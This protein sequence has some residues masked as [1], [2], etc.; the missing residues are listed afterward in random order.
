MGDDPRERE[1]N[2]R[3]SIERW[4]EARRRSSGV[5]RWFGWIAAVISFFLFR[6]RR[7]LLV[8]LVLFFGFLVLLFGVGIKWTRVYDC[9]VAE[10]SHS[11]AVLEHL[12]HPVE[13][14]FFAWCPRY[15]QG[16]S[17]T[18]T[19]FRTTLKGPKGEGILQVWW[20][21]SPLG[22]SLR[23][24]LDKNGQTHQVYSGAIPCH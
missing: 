15:S 8:V 2:F 6:P 22:S 20:Y 16:G 24:E 10:A 1:Q 18:D 14:G 7:A 12:G 11:S 21:S 3:R 19:S 13:A 23:M 9:S 17:I 5:R 4:A